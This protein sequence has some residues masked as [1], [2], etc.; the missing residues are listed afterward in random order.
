MSN[1]EVWERAII[2]PGQDI[3][4]LSGLSNLSVELTHAKQKHPTFMWNAEAWRELL[5]DVQ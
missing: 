2:L 4:R 1:W 3:L 5:G